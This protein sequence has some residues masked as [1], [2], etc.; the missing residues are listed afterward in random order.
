MKPC[1]PSRT[2][3]MQRS[4]LPVPVYTITGTLIA[5][6][7]IARS[8]SKPSIPG[9]SRSRITQSTGSR[10]KISSASSPE[11]AASVSWPP[12]RFKS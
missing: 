2:A 1:A 7:S 3:W 5:G 6:R 4:K 8:T 10:L 9:I 12:R 11:R